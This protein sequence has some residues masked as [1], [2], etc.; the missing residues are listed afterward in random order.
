MILENGYIETLD[1]QQAKEY[2]NYLTIEFNPEIND[3][4][5]IIENDT[6][7]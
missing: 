4:E 2:G 3:I 1:F 7:S 5:T 6:E